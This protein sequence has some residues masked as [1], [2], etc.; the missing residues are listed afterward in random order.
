VKLPPVTRWRAL[1]AYP[2]NA[3]GA[4]E[5]LVYARSEVSAR[6][7]LSK[8]LV[9]NLDPTTSALYPEGTIK[10]LDGRVV[11][12]TRLLE[13]P[14]GKVLIDRAPSRETRK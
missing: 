2:S 12:V 7:R 6:R 1:V 3:G 13:L 4:R 8:T 10:I 14:P 9:S 5:F 11:E